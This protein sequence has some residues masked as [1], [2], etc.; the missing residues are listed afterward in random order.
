M[1]KIKVTYMTQS[2]EDWTVVEL[3][4]L[5]DFIERFPVMKLEWVN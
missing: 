4:N 2:G 1:K 5:L 3:E